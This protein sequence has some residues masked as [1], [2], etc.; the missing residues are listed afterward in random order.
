[1]EKEIWKPVKDYEGIYEISNSGRLKSLQRDVHRRGYGTLVIPE[2]ILTL[3]DD[4]RGYYFRVLSKQGSKR[5]NARI[6]RLVAEAFIPNPYNKPCID[7]IN[8]ITTDNHVD[9]LRW[10]TY[11]ENANFELARKHQSESK[12]G[13][14]NGMYRKCG[15]DSHSSKEVLQFDLQGNFIRNFYGLAE[16]QRLTGVCFQNISKVCKRERPTAGG[17]IWRFKEDKI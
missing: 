9:N 10:C 7:H 5:K 2:R 13:E 3:V 14:R 1:M 15:K 6:H 4:G 8:G 11:K 17:F 16:A 12:M